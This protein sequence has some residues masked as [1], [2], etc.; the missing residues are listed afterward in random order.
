MKSDLIQIEAISCL[1]FQTIFLMQRHL[2]TNTVSLKHDYKRAQS[3]PFLLT[4]PF[5]LFVFIFTLLLILL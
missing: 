5:V 2:T 3:D 1:K 4:L